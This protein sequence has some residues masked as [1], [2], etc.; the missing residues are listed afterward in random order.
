M[1]RIRS[2]L[3]KGGVADKLT[4]ALHQ[5]W[6]NSELINNDDLWDDEKEQDIPNAFFG[7]GD[8]NYPKVHLLHNSRKP[9][10]FIDTPYWRRRGSKVDMRSA[11]W[12][13]CIGSLHVNKIIK[14]LDNRRYPGWDIKPWKTDKRT[15]VLVAESSP[16]INQFI[17]EPHWES[18]AKKTLEPT[19]WPLIHRKKPRNGKQSGPDFAT[20]P[21]EDDFAK[22]EF[23]FSS[24]SIV[25]VEAVI[26]GIPVVCHSLSAAAPVGSL[27]VTN[28][29][30]PDRRDWFKTL[31]YH[32][33]TIDEMINGSA[34]YI[35]K[36]LYI[37]MY[38]ELFS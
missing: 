15:H 36:D 27:D 32:Q 8:F 14:D 5:G 10:V 11:L 22:A 38:P 20:I 35:L 6:V 19:R 37:E 29:V 28:I 4:S 2:P 1:L 33:F 12:R 26:N 31:Q 16:T 34:Y 24:C 3:N 9:Y 30:K 18:Y 7:L 17:G 23:V 25:G 21:L 13:I